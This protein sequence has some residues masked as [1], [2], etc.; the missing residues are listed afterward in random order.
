MASGRE[1][2]DRGRAKRAPVPR[3]H[4]S[5]LYGRYWENVFTVPVQ[6]EMEEV[7]YTFSNKSKHI[8]QIA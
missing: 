8:D 3:G 4:Q 7:Y 1:T 5:Q 6:V 2:K